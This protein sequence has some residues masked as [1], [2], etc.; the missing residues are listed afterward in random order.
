MIVSIDI[1]K[2]FDKIPH[3]FMIKNY[4]LDTE[5]IYL[6]VIKAI[7]MKSSQAGIILSGKK[8][9]IFL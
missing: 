7:Y 8:L 1:G 9:N 3:S 2:E 5:G 4:K 6:N